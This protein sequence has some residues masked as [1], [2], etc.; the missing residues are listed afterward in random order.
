MFYIHKMDD[1]IKIIWKY[2]NANQRVQYST[3]VFIGNKVPK[4]IM[5]ILNKISELN[6]YDTLVTLAKSD[7]T[8][9]NLFYGNKW[10]EKFFNVYHID[11]TIDIIRESSVQK[12]ELE[13]KFGSEWY[14]KNI[15]SR[16]L[17]Q[18]EIIYSYEALIKYKNEHK[19]MKD[20][21]LGFG[22]ED[23]DIDYKT[24]KDKIIKN[25]E[26]ESTLSPQ[27]SVL[28][29]ND[30]YT[31][32]VSSYDLSDIDSD[33]EII[34]QQGGGGEIEEH[35]FKIGFMQQGGQDIEDEIQQDD[36]LPN[37]D[38]LVNDENESE[39][40][41]SEEKDEEVEENEEA[42]KED[43]TDELMEIEDMYKEDVVDDKVSTTSELIKKAL[44]DNNIFEKNM[45]NMVDFDTSADNSEYHNNLK[46]LYKKFYVTTQYI[47]KD[48][49]IKA[50]RNKIS[51][52]MKMN[53]RFGND[54]YLIPSRQ[55]FWIEYQFENKIKKISIGQKWMRKNELLDIDVEPNHN[56]KVYEELRGSLKTLRDNMKR[57]NNKIRVEDEDN[58]ILFDYD[59]YMINN[60]IYMIDLYNEFGVNFNPDT[61]AQKNL[62][63]VYLKLYFK[64]IKSEDFK[65]ILDMLN[66]NNDTEIQK[67]TF[68]FETINNDLTLENEIVST[69]EDVKINEKDKYAYLFKNNYITQSVI[70]VNLRYSGDHKLNLYKIYNNFILDDTYPFAQYQ[71]A[72]GNNVYKFS[73]KHIAE[74][75]G[76]KGNTDLLSKWFENTPYGISIK[77]RATDKTGEKFLSINL[78][79]NG[80]IEYKT[81][82]KEEDMAT[83]E[84]IKKTYVY[85][86]NL[87]NKFNN[88]KSGVT[89]EILR[90]SEFKYAFINT[91]Q[92]FE[93]PGKHTINHN[94][95]SNFSRYFF[96]FVALVI[97]P[98]K[99]QSKIQ[100][101][102]IEKSKYG[103]YLR[104]KKVS[105]YENQGRI[106]QRIMYF[107][108]N[109]EF[110]EKTLIDELSKQFNITEDKAMEEL[111]RVQAKYPNLKKARK[112]LKKLENI[113]KF[114]PPGIGID[115]QGKD[116]TKYKIRIS[117]ARSKVQLD[118]IITFMNILIYLYVE[119]YIL[120][121]P[122]KQA[123]KKKLNDLENIAKRRNKV[124]YFVKY[125]KDIAK[126]KQMIKID[127]RRIGFKP[128]KGQNQWSRSCQNS[129]DDKK[130]RPQQYNS[131]HIDD[132]LKMGYFLNKKT[133]N[134]E[135]KTRV[136]EQGKTK[137]VV[138]RAV[139][140]AEYDENGELSGNDLFYTCDPNLNGE[141]F[142]VGF[143]TKSKNPFGQC[144]PCCF[145]KD[146][147][148]ATSKKK[149]EFIEN[150]LNPKDKA[151]T[152]MTDSGDKLYVLQDTNKLHD[153]RI[154]FLP[155][156][157]DIYFNMLLN[158]VKKIKHHYLVQSKTGYFFKYGSPQ[159]NYAFLNCVGTLLELTID[160]IKEKIVTFLTEK[161]KNL[162]YFTALNNGEIKSQFKT[163]NNFIDYINKSDF[164][165]YSLMGDLISMPN[166]LT[167]YGLNMVIFTKKVIVV[168]DSFEKDRTR[169]NFYIYCQNLENTDGLV[170]K[171][172]DCIFILKE[173]Q[174]YYP[175]VMVQKDIEGDRSLHIFKK[176]NYE[177]DKDNI[178]NH[179]N[180]FYQRSCL[181]YFIEKK[182][183]GISAKLTRKILSEIKDPE[184]HVK[185][186]YIDPK[187]KCKYLIT[188]N[189][190]LVPV[191]PSGSLY[192]VQIIKN[193]EKY[194]KEYDVMQKHITDLHSVSGKQIP[195]NQIGVYLDA[196]KKQTSDKIIINGIM[197]D[198]YYLVPILSHETSRKA[199]ENKGLLIEM[200]PQIEDIDVAIEK[201]SE[202]NTIDKR[203]Q[204][205][206]I[207]KYDSES[208]ELFRLEFSN[209]INDSENSAMKSKLIN[210]INNTSFDK[211][212]KTQKVK[213][214]LYKLVDDEL[215]QKYKKI[216]GDIQN[217]GYIQSGGKKLVF[218][219]DKLPDL[220]NYQ[221]NNDK[222]ICGSN[223]NKDVCS[224]H[225]HCR[226]VYSS[227]T[228][229][230]TVDNL[231]KMINKM[232]DEL[233]LND[234]KAFEILRI[235][236]YF[237]SDIG[238]Y[239][240][241][242]ERKGQT[243]VK[244]TSS[245]ISKVL[246]DTFGKDRIFYKIG[247]KKMKVIEESYQQ[248]NQ[249]NPIIDMKTFY[250]QK[251][252]GANMTLFRAYTNGYYWN[253]NKYSDMQIRNL[254][255]Y[256][257]IQTD[258][259]IY[260]K[261]AVVD[262]LLKPTN[263]KYITPN[264]KKY[265]NSKNNIDDLIEIFIL[266]LTKEIANN[267]NCIFELFVI[268]QINEIPIVVYD[269]YQSL[270][271]VFDKG[272][273]FD[274]NLNDKV[275][276][277]QKKYL[278]NPNYINLRFVLKTDDILVDR[279]DVI[280]FM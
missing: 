166:I 114:K 46:D 1:P 271:Y 250:L 258:L 249:E 19:K 28:S 9:M 264:V 45:S 259:A 124:D 34:G 147:L 36:D 54:L 178:V 10:Y 215:Y 208:Y 103:T 192:D 198:A 222:I 193:I 203:I 276:N 117:G 185:Y 16:K 18:K 225:P 127:K 93:L 140:F 136:K 101:R 186:Q 176:F 135:R 170:N 278:N 134:Y 228:F 182:Q 156:Y 224:I 43:E 254:G 207:W 221:I 204:N 95:L 80:R 219:T 50:I 202:Y 257:P 13:E 11:L 52:S 180:D 256:H 244:S 240:K 97:D 227:C 21:G 20:R 75:F 59:S 57:Y 144:M 269:E 137:D 112:V 174:N 157:L 38:D 35:E 70:H 106:E 73:E 190:I 248:L 25:T 42:I 98:K 24:T 32:S 238:D 237:V 60:E 100:Q 210:I 58:N 213:L 63:D 30:A 41:L 94:D 113:S 253:K 158:K 109:F 44:N 74:Y 272:L 266:K 241:F 133:G 247:K 152:T 79:E 196:Q 48:D 78:Y 191:F 64:K 82:W 26:S 118:R 81:Q 280:Y 84:D 205:V 47:F 161:D 88:E 7:Y 107:I 129:G 268:N 132:M 126:V 218:V 92:K 23:I 275:G 212:A 91:I 53:P 235:G 131:T 243:I 177:N 154:G 173:D 111:K 87:I 239:N 62:Q 189:D 123:I 119:T 86:Y 4:D 252:I 12:K 168:N 39:S 179:V 183:I 72:D 76:K 108:R 141:H 159:D 201:G 69:V 167:K 29:E 246:N 115:I 245:N 197:T 6:F 211:S 67:N 273:I 77:T 51:C 8:K 71:T 209:F 3:Y 15:A 83:F 194:I 200:N 148:T 267:T 2:K 145:K 160:Q 187:N 121:N 150:C 122:K 138:L 68:I 175:I 125:S 195:I 49:S 265:F 164:L 56:I 31:S 234:L 5:D 17:V 229:I 27:S 263:L 104:Y 184:Y 37:E 65:I 223:P 128:E 143:L 55:Y 153:G 130:R 242:T 142:Y 146:Q 206:N 85:I 61:N 40:F 232:T 277:E 217:G 89:F 255:Y 99:R 231:I 262:W 22:N 181:E 165:D 171:N 233:V 96:P 116:P 90:D 33:S 260:F 66:K 105:K 169:E 172:R 214:F 251:I 230:S 226:W 120:K 151:V 149:K 216:S 102:D 220:K 110:Y 163:I 162:Q 270:I 199:I 236:T 14:E 188:K 139:K 155:Q 279:I 274:A 261:S